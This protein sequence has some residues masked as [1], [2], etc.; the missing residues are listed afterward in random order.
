MTS[1]NQDEKAVKDAEM[2]LS[3]M[4]DDTL[5]T[6]SDEYA[7]EAERLGRLA[8]GAHAELQQ[9]MRD[10]GATV[11]DTPNWAGKMTPGPIMHSIVN[12]D[13]LG[14]RKRLATLLS[15]EQIEA[16]FVL[17][18]APPMHVDH[19]FI[20]EYRKQ[21]GVIASVIDEFRKSVR[22]EDRLVLKRK[23]ESEA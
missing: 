2:M 5:A 1:V 13:V 9:R 20:N 21:G 10:R 6:L 17:P 3:E 8:R 16:A 22:G 11:L 12:D 7:R 18:L 14:F 15:V 23:P 4:S 19:R